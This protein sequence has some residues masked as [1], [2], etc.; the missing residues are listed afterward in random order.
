MVFCFVVSPSQSGQAGA[1]VRGLS[2]ADAA[3]SAGPDQPVREG[4]QPSSV[5][6]H[7]G[8]GGF[9][10]LGIRQVFF[11]FCVVLLLCV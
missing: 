9:Q 4:R 8:G 7:A 5:R 6:P 2:K 3:D 11:F 10:R 1:S